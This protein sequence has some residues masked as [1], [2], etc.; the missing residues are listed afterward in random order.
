MKS[1]IFIEGRN[2]DMIERRT[3]RSVNTVLSSF[4]MIAIAIQITSCSAKNN[5]S[6]ILQTENSVTE[7]VLLDSQTSSGD[8]D[9]LQK[10]KNS[11]YDVSYT[12]KELTYKW[13]DDCTIVS[14]SDS[15][16]KVEGRGAS[17]SGSTLNITSAGTYLLSGNINEGNVIV[18]SSDE[19]AVRLVF[20]GLSINC[21]TTAPLNVIS[22]DKVIITL[23]NG[24]DNIIGDTARTISDDDN[25][26][27][28][29]TIYSKSD[30]TFNGAGTLNV[31][32]GFCDAIVSKDKL[33]FV[34]G[35]FKIKAA[36]DA[37]IGRDLVAVRDAEFSIQSEGDGIKTTN[38]TDTEKGNIVIEGGTFDI[39]TAKDGIQADNAVNIKDGTFNIT[40]GDGSTNGRNHIPDDMMGGGKGGFGGKNFNQNDKPDTVTDKKSTLTGET[41]TVAEETSS[42]C[43]G[44]KSGNKILIDNGTIKINSADDSIHSDNTVMI[45]SGK[46]NILSGDDGIHATE[47]MEINGGEVCIKKSYEGLEGSAIRINDGVVYIVSSDDGVN[48]SA[49]DNSKEPMFSVNGGYLCVDASGDGLDSNGNIEINDGVVIVNGPVSNGDGPLD[50]GDQNNSISVNGGV[51]VAAGSAGM[52]ELPSSDSKQNSIAI[53]SLSADAGTICSLT[54]EKNNVIVAFKVSK[55]SEAMVISTPEIKKNNKYYIYKD[56]KYSGTLNDDGFAE[57]GTLLSGT[58]AGNCTPSSSVTTIG[59]FQGPMGGGNHGGM[60]FQNGEKPEKPQG[61]NRGDFVPDENFVPGEGR[62]DDKGF[63]P[64]EKKQSEE[65]Q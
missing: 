64:D 33:K 29:G 31:S 5:T 26:M 58:E 43:R 19:K 11:E 49:S 1:M 57:G 22:A 32:A 24:T 34:S 52:F 12:E 21:S 17:A 39:Q 4:I 28:K 25:D 6:K 2:S 51:L 62:P 8:S 55:T 50:Y 7:K 60:P 13:D 59:Q 38:D 27:P 14:A 40:S 16:F 9:K 47:D 15:G 45:N 37:I 65:I 18:N 23:V 61:G 36:D 53:A 63:A 20:N 35:D 10:N 54:D 48:A 46:L 56:G 3:R 41:D 30:L 44:I 42:G